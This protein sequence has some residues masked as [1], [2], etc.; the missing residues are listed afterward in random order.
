MIKRHNFKNL[1]WID[2]FQPTQDELREI[3]EEFNIHPGVT[4]DLLTPTYKPTVDLYKDFI[5]AVIHFPALKHTHSTEPNQEVDFI[6]GKKFLITSRYDTIDPIHKFSR[7]FEVNSVLEKENIME[8]GWYLFFLLINKLYAAIDHEIECIQ[9]SLKKSEEMI[10]RGEEK[11][12]VKEL[13]NTSRDLLNL[14]QAT[15]THK[16]TLESLISA[17]EE[18]FGEDFA[19]H[20]QSVIDEYQ[21]LRHTIEINRES[22]TELRNTNN[23]LLS[24]KQNE[25]MTVLTIM[26]FVTFP[27][28]LLASV[29][30]MNAQHM[31]I[32]GEPY[33]FW[34][35][36]GVM[37]VLASIFFFFFKYKK[38]L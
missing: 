23:S 32:V 30:G 11:K 36:V 7:V 20:M 14:K 9:D 12:M 34:I 3:M 25:T 33:D 28:S 6:I 15:N 8:E 16:D 1:T 37:L 19:N 13:S 4:N 2:L 10:F 18:L 26:A 21:K 22:L 35:I 29:F 31:P 24:T 5:Y 38:W 27:L 17:G